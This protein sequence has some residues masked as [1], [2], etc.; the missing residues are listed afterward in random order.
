MLQGIITPSLPLGADN[1]RLQK[2]V[3]VPSTMDGTAV[4]YGIQI[5]KV[6]FKSELF[7][8]FLS[9]MHEYQK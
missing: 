1:T 6:Y 3:V 7:C 8:L 5:T 4:E 2:V 9:R